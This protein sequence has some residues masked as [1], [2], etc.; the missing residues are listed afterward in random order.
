MA[1]KPIRPEGSGGYG[2]LYDDRLG[3]C[4]DRSIVYEPD[5]LMF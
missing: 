2:A 1:S 4:A 3:F 5:E